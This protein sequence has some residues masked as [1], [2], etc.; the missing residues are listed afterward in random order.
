MAV[1]RCIERGCLNLTSK[2]RCEPHA[3]ERERQRK[4][5]PS[6]TGRRTGSGTWK[7]A[8]ELRLAVD[9][10]RCVQ[11]GRKEPELLTLG[12]RL[13]VHHVDGDPKNDQIANLVTLC[14]S[15]RGS[16]HWKVEDKVR[17]NRYAARQ[18]PVARP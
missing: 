15:K 3:V 11:C 16:C 1:R 5:D 4:K 18:Q 2:T 10:W 7:R 6:V 13:E 14:G 8:R 12:L 17:R 9:G